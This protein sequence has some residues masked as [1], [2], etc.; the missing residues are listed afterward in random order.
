MQQCYVTIDTGKSQS[1]CTKTYM[2]IILKKNL[3]IRDDTKRR[4]V[5]DKVKWNVA[6]N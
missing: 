2:H 6:C 3:S 5:N 4:E 1:N